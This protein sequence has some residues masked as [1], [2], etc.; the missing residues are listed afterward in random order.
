M[1]YLN[2]CSWL[3]ALPVVVCLG[4][5]AFDATA[6]EPVKIGAVEKVLLTEYGVTVDARIDT[7]AE[8]SSL[9]AR[10]IRV[11]G[12][13]NRKHV[14]ATIYLGNGQRRKINTRVIRISKVKHLSF[15]SEERPVIMVALCLGQR[16]RLIEVTLTNRKEKNY[17]MSLGQSAL[18]N[19][20]ALDMTKQ[21][22]T[23][24]QC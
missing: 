22:L 13:K 12:K 16:Y 3:V 14:T 20:Y 24:P 23:K 21:N 18:G 8:T 5:L 4:I 6:K 9:D 17:R 2:H 10:T 11:L 1:R 7:G 19:G 15:L